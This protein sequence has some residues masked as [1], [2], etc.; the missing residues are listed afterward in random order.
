[1]GRK[2]V[3]TD[4]PTELNDTKILEVVVA[5]DAFDGLV[6]G[7]RVTALIEAAAA[8]NADANPAR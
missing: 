2:N 1:M 6:V 3:R 5:L 4:D 7:Q 8:R